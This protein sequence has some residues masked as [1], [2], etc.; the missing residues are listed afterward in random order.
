MAQCWWAGMY[1]RANYNVRD[2]SVTSEIPQSPLFFCLYG[3]AA[4][5]LALQLHQERTQVTEWCDD[6][7]CFYYCKK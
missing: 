5:Q 3:Y 6:D 4:T 7:D 2:P 1:P